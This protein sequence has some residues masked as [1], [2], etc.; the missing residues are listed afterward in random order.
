[1]KT[2]RLAESSEGLNS[3]LAQLNCKH[4]VAKWCEN[5]GFTGKSTRQQ[6]C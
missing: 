1:L 4:G 2:R 3:S 6:R 5:M